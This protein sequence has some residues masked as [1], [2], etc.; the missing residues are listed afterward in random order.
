MIRA[1][2]FVITSLSLVQV[3]AAHHGGGTFDNTKEIELS[4]VLTRLDLGQMQ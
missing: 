3:A 4:G 2:A 1:A